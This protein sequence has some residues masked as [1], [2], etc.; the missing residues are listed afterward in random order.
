[1]CERSFE[2]QILEREGLFCLAGGKY[3]DVERDAAARPKMDPHDVAMI[4]YTSGTTGC[5]KGVML[6]HDNLISNVSSANE[7]VGLTNDDS[8]LLV[9]PFYFIHGRMQLIAHMRL[10][11]TVAVS[12][13]FQLP[14]RVV[15]ELV[16]YGVTGLSGVPYHFKLLL[17]RA[18]LAETSIPTLRYVLITGGAMSSE[19]LD[20]LAEALPGVEIQLAYGQTEA[21]PRITYQG[22][23]D[24]F[25]EKRGSCGIPLPGVTVDIVDSDGRSIPPGEV[26]EVAAGGPGVMKGYVT[27]DERASGKIDQQGRLRTGD[28]GY[29]DG[30]GYLFLSGRSSEMIK[31]AGERVFPGEIEGVLNT[32]PSIVESAV[33]GVPD[34]TL[35]ER[36]VALVVLKEKHELDLPA[37]RSHCLQ[38]MPFVRIPREVRVLDEL[39][40]TSSGKIN[41]GKLGK[42]AADPA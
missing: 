34:D 32:H 9:V 30:D 29:L 11:G 10:G 20:Q 1:M 37:L 19:T 15:R 24:V 8:I 27:G 25:G 6:S 28:L 39:P 41:R 12:A 36:I 14:G 31:T 4:V 23:K 26:G 42:V 40:K 17:N 33:V 5:P 16:E 2:R 22:P 3:A 38:S 18:R 13:G 7:L 35:G 21:S